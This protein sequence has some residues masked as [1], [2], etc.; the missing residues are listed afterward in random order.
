MHKMSR[1]LLVGMAVITSVL[2]HEEVKAQIYP[3]NGGPI[4]ACSGGLVASNGLSGGGYGNNEDFVTT[5]CSDVAGQGIFLT[6]VAFDLSL[7]GPGTVDQFMI[8]DGPDE[9]SPLIGTYIGEELQGQIIAVTPDNTSGCLTVHFTSN[10]IGEGTFSAVISCGTPCWP[11]VPN[12]VITGEALPARVCMDEPISFDASASAASPGQTIATYAWNMDDGTE[13]TG[14][15]VSHSFTEPGQYL[16]SLQLTDDTGCENTQQTTVEVWVGTEP[17]FVGTTPDGTVCEG[18]PVQLMGAAQGVTWSGLPVIDLGGQIDLPDQTGQLFTSEVD[19]SVFD[20]AALLTDVY[21]LTSICVS[22]EHTFMGDFILSITCP[23]G[24]NAIL[25][26]QGGGGTFLGDANDT[27]M[28]SN[29]VPGTCWDY[30]FSASATL[31]TWAD[32]AQFGTTP[33]VMTTSQGTALVPGTYSSVDPFSDL[34]GCPLNGVWT[35]GFVDQWAADN[36]TMCNWSINFDPS[37]YPDLTEFT[38]HVGTSADSAQWTGTGLIVDPSDPSLA[39]T[40][41]TETGVEE[42]IYTVTDD[43]GCTY[44]TT[45]TITVRNAPRVDASVTSV[46]Q[47][48]DPARLRATIVAYA[49]PPG[50][51]PLI[52]AWTPAAGTTAPSLPEPF[53]QITE[54]TLFEVSVYPNGQPWCTTSDTIRVDP[55]SFLGNDSTIIN[56]LCLGEQ[57]SVTISSDGPGG[58][59]NYEWRDAQNAIIR[60]TTGAVGDDLQAT[61]GSYS[62]RVSEG[63]NGN[64]C[65]D[66]LL[67][68]ITEPPLLAWSEVPQ[69]TLICLTAEHQLSALALGG[70]GSIILHWSQGLA[71]NGPHTVSPNATTTY[72]VVAEDANGCST[73]TVAAI[74]S[75]LD[76]I[77]FDTLSDFTQCSGVPFTLNAS[78][79]VGGNGDY[80]Y[81]WNNGASSAPLIVDSLFNDAQLCVTVQDGCESPPVTSCADITVLHT[82]PLVLT[83][84]SALGCAPFQVRFALRDTTEGASILWDFGDNISTLGVDSINHIYSVAGHYSVTATATWPNGCITDTTITQLVRVIPVPVSDFAWTP[85]PL[86]VFE[87]VAQFYETAES[88][89]VAYA[90]D[91]F[92]FG[93]SEE[94]DPTIIFPNDEGRYYPVQLVVENILGCADT[95]LRLVHVEDQFLVYIPNAFS[96]NGDGI[97]EAFYVEGNDIS[98]DEF[99]LYIFDRWGKQVFASVDPLQPWYGA[100]GSGDGDPLPAGEYNWRLTIRSKQ[101]LQKRIMMGHVTLLR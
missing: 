79:A 74:V 82:P 97:N 14:P 30:C 88:N 70:T 39:S 94:P 19:F 8:Y 100:W 90:W 86:T 55:P 16:V 54:T 29:I 96:P 5:I 92:E 49:L 68:E 12:A 64:G 76:P 53:T 62:V 41:L 6:F 65:S 50:S 58:P 91:F 78:N 27:D 31:G 2:F 101:T 24:Q 22:M 84:D 33:N 72:R 42:F 4:T 36:G 89:E 61:A 38:P 44:D 85:D 32:C 21:D 80:T 81:I 1:T 71:G 93:T 66:T 99:Q 25:H 26:Q 20:N 18:A 34:L 15:L 11:P 46:G 52:Y 63:A 56:A 7:A 47:C 43:F 23:N 87:P 28:G 17:E 51:S 83:V 10:A 67:V 98:Q 3:I 48:E 13:L 60:T 57:G 9:G 45:I 73:D 69:D 35:L 95:L 59:W 40:V 37:L 77:G 75:V